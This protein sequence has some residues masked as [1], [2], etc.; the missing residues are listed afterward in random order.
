MNKLFKTIVKSLILSGIGT[1]LL[2]FAIAKSVDEDTFRSQVVSKD[3]PTLKETFNSDGDFTYRVEGSDLGGREIYLEL[4]GKKLDKD[5]VDLINARFIPYK[6][7]NYKL[8]KGKDFTVKGYAFGEIKVYQLDPK[9]SRITQKKTF[10]QGFLL[11]FIIF[12]GTAFLIFYLADTNLG[13]EKFDFK[14]DN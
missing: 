5:D 9:D 11:P 12:G 6:G 2:I 1:L 7:N 4:D 13:K 3:E 10:I 8:I 14:I